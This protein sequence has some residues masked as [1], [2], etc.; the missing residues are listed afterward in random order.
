MPKE[1]RIHS[2]LLLKD[3]K[4]D[5]NDEELIYTQKRVIIFHDIGKKFEKP[6]LIRR[7]FKSLS[8]TFFKKDSSYFDHAL[9]GSN[10]LKTEG[11]SDEVVNM[12]RKHHTKSEDVMFLKK[13]EG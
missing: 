5:T 10:I 7:V 12:V 3:Y 9:I 8:F 6:S 2:L 1:D 4:P 13:L 11:F